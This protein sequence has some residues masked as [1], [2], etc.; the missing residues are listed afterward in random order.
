MG[1]GGQIAD[2][3]LMPTL[4]QRSIRAVR[5]HLNESVLVQHNFLFRAVLHLEAAPDVINIDSCSNRR[6]CTRP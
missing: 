2:A 4:Y 6:S 1:E 3:K 5:S